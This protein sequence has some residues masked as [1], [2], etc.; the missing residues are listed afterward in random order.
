MQLVPNAVGGSGRGPILG[1]FSTIYSHIVLKPVFAG[2][3]LTKN[4]YINMNISFSGKLAV[5]LKTG[6][7]YLS[8]KYTVPERLSSQFYKICINGDFKNT[9]FFNSLLNWEKLETKTRLILKKSIFLNLFHQ[10]GTT[11]KSN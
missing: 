8:Y 11:G 5:S 4:C 3:K 2:L 6:F 10:W 7:F 1:K 9:S